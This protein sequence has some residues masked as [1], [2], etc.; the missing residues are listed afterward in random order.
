MWW[1]NPLHIPISPVS[2]LSSH[3]HFPPNLICS[4]TKQKGLLTASYIYMVR[5]I[6]EHRWPLRE[7]ITFLKKTD[8]PPNRR[9]LSTTPQ[10]VVPNIWDTPTPIHA[11]IFS[12]LILHR[13]VASAE[14]ICIMTLW[15]LENTIS[16]KILSLVCVWA[17]VT[18]YGMDLPFGNEHSVVPFSLYSHQF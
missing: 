3:S 2:C 7:A 4:K 17:S 11:G 5:A 16:L 6:P 18:V 14:I 1:S 10:Q 8:F 13:L 15:C 12:G 9:R